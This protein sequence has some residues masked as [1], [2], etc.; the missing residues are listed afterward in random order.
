MQSV[1]HDWPGSPD[2]EIRSVTAPRSLVIGDQ[3][4]VRVDHAA[5]MLD[6]FPTAAWSSCPARS[7]PRSC[8]DRS[9]SGRSS[10]PSWPSWPAH[11]R[12]TRPSEPAFPV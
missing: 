6:L 8:S 12:V 11:P 5:E 9:S 3:D 2:D 7:T 10:G 1:V 4:F